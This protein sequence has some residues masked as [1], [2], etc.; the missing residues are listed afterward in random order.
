MKLPETYSQTFYLTVRPNGLLS[1]LN[2]K[3]VDNDEDGYVVLSEHTLT[4]DVPQE[5][6]T[7]KVIDCLRKAISTIR[8]DSERKAQGL[9]E[10]I[11]NLLA[12]PNPD[13]PEN[14]SDLEVPF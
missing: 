6:P 11:Q 7:K 1:L 14:A 9:E 3:V 12:L 5:D 8:A 2:W 13:K 4:V 10:K